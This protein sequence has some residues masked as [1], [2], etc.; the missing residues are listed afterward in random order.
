MVKAKKLIPVLTPPDLIKRIR[1]F[2]GDLKRL[3]GKYNLELFANEDASGEVCI[4]GC[5]YPDEDGWRKGASF[6]SVDVDGVRSPDGRPGLRI[7]KYP[8]DYREVW[9]PDP[10]ETKAG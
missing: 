8:D 10:E 7:E 9:G 2:M 3:C 4:V 1:S 6:F 5:D